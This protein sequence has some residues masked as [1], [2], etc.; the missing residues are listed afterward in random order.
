MLCKLES[1]QSNNNA[2]NRYVSE[3]F[4]SKLI[5]DAEDLV[6]NS[7]KI[8][9]TAEFR[10]RTDVGRNFAVSVLE[11]FDRTGSPSRQRSTRSINPRGRSAKKNN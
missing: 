8:L 2:R 6:A 10:N 7:D 11:Y 4:L 1:N 9:T 5:K 3:P